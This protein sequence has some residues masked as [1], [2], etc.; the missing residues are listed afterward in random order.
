MKQFVSRKYFIFFLHLRPLGL[1]NIRFT[2]N[3]SL[4]RNL[5]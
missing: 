4:A 2:C 3:P 5:P 1:P